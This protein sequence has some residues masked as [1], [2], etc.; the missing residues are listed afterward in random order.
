MYGSEAEPPIAVPPPVSLPRAQRVAPAVVLLALLGSHLEASGN[1]AE[2]PDGLP[3]VS[4]IEVDLDLDPATGMIHSRSALRVE[5]GEIRTLVFRV[6]ETLAV[7]EVRSDGAPADYRKAGGKLIVEV[8][9][10]AQ[11]AALTVR[12]TGRPRHGKDL[13]VGP[14]LAVLAPR[15]GWYPLAPHMWAEATVRVKAPPGWTAIAPGHRAAVEP[16][17]VAVWRTSG[18]VRT[19]AVAAAPGLVLTEALAIRTPVRVAAPEGRPEASAVA[20]RL[21]EALSWLSA[22]LAPYPFDGFNL[23]FAP[24]WSGRARA[25]GLMIVPASAEVGSKPE[26]ADLL[27]GQWFGERVAGDGAWIEAFAAWQA[28]V[29]CRDRGWPL[30]QETARLREAYFEVRGPRDVPLA[31]AGWDAPAEILRGKGSAAPDMI[32]LVTGNRPFFDAVR[33]LFA[34]P[35]GPPLSLAQLRGFFERTAGRSLE[36]AFADWF[37]RTGAPDLEATMQTLPASTGGYRVDLTLVQRSGAYA[38]PVEVVFEGPGEEH[39]EV[40]EVEAEKTTPFYV[41]PFEPRRVRVDPGGKIYRYGAPL[42]DPGRTG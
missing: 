2:V 28:V 27:A 39:R 4:R 14:A 1:P 10:P 36:R 31:R 3:W 37:E 25:S 33:A 26:A 29:V 24:G 7:E 16:A 35:V 5:G 15:D 34:R 8:D 42:A 13:A 11:R 40:V 12:M 21:A 9:P 41:L 30:P 38:L 20:E 32:R 23:V 18:P 19:L 17:G 22:A 6:N